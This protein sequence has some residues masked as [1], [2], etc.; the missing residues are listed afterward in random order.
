MAE[1]AHLTLWPNPNDGSIMNVSLTEFDATVNTV[2]MDVT[3]V[4]GK[5]VSTRNLQ[6]QD[7]RLNT[8][9]NFEQ[10][11]APGLYLVNLQAGD[12]RYTERLVV[13]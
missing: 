12:H 6:V 1:D 13:Q 9:V 2:T 7:G 10:E 11:L 5:L 4:F 8:V 3:D